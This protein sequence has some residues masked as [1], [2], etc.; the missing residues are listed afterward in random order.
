MK[1]FK[2]TSAIIYSVLFCSII[3]A[4]IVPTTLEEIYGKDG[5]TI[6]MNP[7]VD[8]PLAANWIQGANMPYPRYYSGSVTYTRN[9]T[10]W[11]YVIGGDTSGSGDA[12]TS[13]LK[14]NVNTNQW[15]YI[16]PLPVPMRTNAATRIG[17]KIY[18][19]GGF[20]APF[21]SP[22]LNS[23]FE[24]N[25][26]TNTW[27]QLPD[28]PQTVFFHGAESFEDSLIYI[29]GGIEYTP[30]RSEIISPKVWVC[31]LQQQ[32]FRPA[33]DMPKGTASFGHALHFD[34]LTQKYSLFVVGGLQSET[35]LW[36][37]TL[38]GEINTNDRSQIYWTLKTNYQFG[39]YAHYG[40]TYPNNEIYFAG[41]S[42][43]TGFSPINDVFSY[44]PDTDEYEAEDPTPI[45]WMATS[46]GVNYSN[47]NRSGSQV[48]VMV[49]AGGITTGP[50]IT[51][52]TWVLTDT[53]ATTGI[54][55]ISNNMPGTFS[56]SQNYPNPFN[57]STKISFFIPKEAFVKLEIY[58]STG[59]K[60][61]TL[62]SENLTAGNYKYEWNA[63][64]F[65]SGIYFYKIIADNFIQTRKM[66]LLK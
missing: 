29:I 33:T 58:N 4:Q 37:T 66:I 8:S 7:D 16:A 39:L 41:G 20:S 18:T 61:S 3:Y 5:F 23:F 48:V 30:S 56:L 31:N 51:K 21:P 47:L 14:Y 1:I 28:I 49:L 6:E 25:I 34:N 9:D 12:T 52:Q 32:N 46:A 62:V 19:M 63:A 43:T 54:N 42:I 65:S 24:Y 40:A 22:A 45:P 27:T 36:N 11:L 64:E 35:D 60:V 57:P 50:T 26:N 44:H 13:C 15:S 17:N 55:H 10:M 38:K 2:I 53:I 59:E